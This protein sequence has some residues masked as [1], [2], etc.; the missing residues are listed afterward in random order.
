MA[1]SAAGTQAISAGADGLVKVWSIK[2]A[3]CINTLDNHEDRIWA[4]CQ[5]VDEQWMYS[6]GSDSLVVVW[7]DVTQEEKEEAIK[8]VQERIERFLLF[9]VINFK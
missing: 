2:T 6:G 9:C 1:F 4:L 5:S 3:E 8:E 7:K